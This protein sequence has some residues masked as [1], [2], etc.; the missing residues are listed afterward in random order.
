[1][2]KR[3]G[4]KGTPP[5]SDEASDMATPRV[6]LDALFPQPGVCGSTQLR[7]LTIAH[8][9]ALE[10]VESPLLAAPGAARETTTMD[11]VQSMAIMSLPADKVF[12][13]M[14]LGGRAAL[15]RLARDFAVVAPIADIRDSA[16]R[17]VEHCRKAFATV[18]PGG[19]GGAGGG[20]EGPL[21]TST[22]PPPAPPASA[23]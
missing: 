12:D 18:L 16:A 1:M 3:K 7:P 13:L 14:E 20:A 4:T 11:V 2:S 9:L 15:E 5:D 6:I 17:V 19:G 23:S 22:V 8:Y 10:L 21:L